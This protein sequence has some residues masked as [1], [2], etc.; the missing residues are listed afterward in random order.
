MKAL[1]GTEAGQISVYVVRPS[2]NKALP[3]VSVRLEREGAEEAPITQTTNG[4]GHA[5]FRELEAGASYVAVATVHGKEVRSNAPIVAAADKGQTLAF[6]FEWPEQEAREARFEGV[7]GGV[8]KVFIAKVFVEGRQFL[9]LPFQLTKTTGAAVGIYMYPELLFSMHG[10]ADLD[11]TRLW[12]QTQISIANP[13][14]APYRPEGSGVSIPLPRGFVGASVA[15]EM[16]SRV[17]VESATGFIWRGAVPPGQRDFISTFAIPVV[18]GAAS[19]DM[20]LPN[21]LRSGRLVLED[22]PGMEL[23][24]PAGAKVT[25]KSQPNGR[26]FLEMPDINIAPQQRLV[27]GV[28]GLPQHSVWERRIRIG[29]GALAILLV[30]WALFVI[31]L[32]RRSPDSVDPV[33]QGLEA[34]REKLLQQMVKLETERRH[35]KI[36]D[37]PYH[38]KR[39]RL[40]SKPADAYRKIDDHKATE[41]SVS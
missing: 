5:F 36:E 2:A 32:G 18:D 25:K 1:P 26:K 27:F 23:R 22:I 39:D 40:S 13:G 24:T 21:G 30:F 31:F 35:N 34:N 37:K 7:A 6:A 3:G 4:E 20:A 11:D 17:G 14:V 38:K 33:L 8:D 12:F 29:V 9:S 28:T 15:D 16:A 41:R 10:G 19:F